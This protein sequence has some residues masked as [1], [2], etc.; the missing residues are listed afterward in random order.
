MF[1][2][3]EAEMVTAF[4]NSVKSQNRNPD[5][6]VIVLQEADTNYGRPDVM[7][8]EYDTAV[9]QRR[10]ISASSIIEK[11][12]FSSE[13]AYAMSYLSQREWTGFEYL[14]QFLNCRKNKLHSI[15]DNLAMR[16]LIRIC[17]ES[18]C[19][20][21]LDENFALRRVLVFE[22]KISK[23]RDAISQAERHLWFTGASYV[24][25]PDERRTILDKALHECAQR[26]VGLISFS[27]DGSLAYLTEP[28]DMKIYNTYLS[29]LINEQVF[30]Q[31]S[32]GTN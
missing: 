8:I 15:I 21:S 26:G 4:V 3:S 5:N 14:Q 29:W 12:S 6:N 22:A 2:T 23:W 18:V 24:I 16:D 30:Q 7:V 20:R 13:C 9:F 32:D 17:K 31:G 10:N 19:S 25:L 11:S 1:W 28:P 27:V